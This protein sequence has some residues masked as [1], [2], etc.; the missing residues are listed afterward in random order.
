[1]Y[2]LVR[3]RNGELIWFSG[4][5]S[6]RN[7]DGCDLVGPIMPKLVQNCKRR[8][9]INRS[10]YVENTNVMLRC[11]KCYKMKVW[12]I[13]NQFNLTGNTQS[14]LKLGRLFLL[15]NQCWWKWNYMKDRH[16]VS[17]F[18]LKDIDDSPESRGGEGVIFIPLFHLTKLQKFISSFATEIVPLFFQSQHMRLPDC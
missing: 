1:M 11:W 18:S 15:E 13:S 2:L 9:E 17:G 3:K 6:E 5:T 4:S 7:W 16:F 12:N 8:S 14:K 10:V